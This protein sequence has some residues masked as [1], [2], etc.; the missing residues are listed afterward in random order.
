[1]A[2]GDVMRTRCGEAPLIRSGASTTRCSTARRDLTGAL[3]VIVARGLRLAWMALIFL[4]SSASSPRLTTDPAL[5]LALKKFGHVVLYVVP[6]VFVAGAVA[7]T[8]WARW[9]AVLAVA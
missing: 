3:G 8:R 2:V 6:A 7:T 9:A 4:F 1:M 5:D